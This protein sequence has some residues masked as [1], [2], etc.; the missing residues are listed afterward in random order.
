MKLAGAY[1]FEAP[2]KVVWDALLAPEVLAATLPGCDKLELVDGV[3]EGALNIKVGP[4][5]GKFQGKV[6]LEDLKE[7]EGY[8]MV[9]DGKGAPGFMKATA[10]ITLEDAEDSTKMGYQSEAKVG[11]RIAS[12]GQR[13]LEASAKAII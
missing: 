6:K 12:V 4:V 9:V 1:T 8:T 7:L 13:L 10:A 11:G 5:Q 2:R 3:Y